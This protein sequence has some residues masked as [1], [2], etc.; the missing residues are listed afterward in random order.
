MPRPSSILLTG[1]LTGL[2]ASLALGCSLRYDSDDLR[3]DGVG[4]ESDAGDG[5]GQADSGAGGRDGGGADSGAPPAD[6]APQPDAAENPGACGDHEEMCC[7]SEPRCGF[8]DPFVECFDG[9][10]LECGDLNE[11]CCLIGDECRDLLLSLCVGGECLP[12]L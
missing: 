1:L 8:G 4:T 10:C 3:P 9:T 2:L 6:A 7:A 5:G 12:I 11:P